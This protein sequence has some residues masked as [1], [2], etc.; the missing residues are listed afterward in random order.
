MVPRRR[1]VYGGLVESE[2]AE[3][4]LLRNHQVPLPCPRVRMPKSLLEHA[5][6]GPTTRVWFSGDM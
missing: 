6:P 5:E 3:R 4:E 1:G 2:S